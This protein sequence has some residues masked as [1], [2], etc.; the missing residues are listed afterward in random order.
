MG[1][2]GRFILALAV[3]I[4]ALGSG[5]LLWPRLSDE[6]RPK[7]LQTV[8]DL[9]LKTTVGQNAANVLG[10]SDEANVQKI[11]FG[12]MASS[13]IGSAKSAVQQR[14]RTVVVTNAV[15]QLDRQFDNLSDEQKTYVRRAICEPQDTSSQ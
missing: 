11:D 5:S 2:T 3:A 14:V 15:N 6:P 4:T 12:V 9:V 1:P 7:A 13:A 10:V 8:H